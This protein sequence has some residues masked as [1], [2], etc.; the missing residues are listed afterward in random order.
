VCLGA[1]S[2]EQ[3]LARPCPCPRPVH[4]K[5][6]ARWML[7]CAPRDQEK[8]CQLPVAAAAQPLARTQ[9]GI[10]L[11]G[12][13][14]YV[15]VHPGPDGKPRFEQLMQVED[16]GDFNSI[17]FECRVAVSS[18]PLHLDGMEEYDAASQCAAIQWPAES[19]QLSVQPLMPPTP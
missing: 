10:L 17:E 12:Q 14:H 7:Q 11:E 8:Q 16:G 4:T 18:T 13:L 5:C 15:H 19:E 3:P 6:L 1:G 9:A 2:P